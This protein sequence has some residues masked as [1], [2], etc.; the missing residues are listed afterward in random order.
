MGWFIKMNGNKITDL[1]T[2][3]DAHDAVNKSYVD[4]SFAP[5]N[6]ISE[7]S[8]CDTYAECMSKLKSVYSAMANGDK[9]FVRMGI[10]TGGTSNGEL[11]GGGWFFELNRYYAD[12]GHI[13][14]TNELYVFRLSNYGGW[15]KWV[16]ASPSAFAPAGY[17]LGIQIPNLVTDYVND[18]NKLTING[19]YNITAGLQNS[20]VTYGTV[21]VISRDENDVLQIVY[22]RDTGKAPTLQ[23]NKVFGTWGEWKQCD[24]SAFAPA[25]VLLYENASPSSTFAQQLVSVQTNG[26]SHYLIEFNSGTDYAMFRSDCGSASISKVIAN[27]SGTAIAMQER[28]IYIDSRGITF[29]SGSAK[30][31]NSTETYVNDDVFIPYRIYGVKG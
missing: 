29:Y 1:G 27:S 30:Y 2:P 10:G 22:S 13:I 21:D 17:G 4:N 3:T 20:P 9:K 16:D 11:S 26:Y 6:F 5:I 31:V 18:L 8:W 28:K 12:Y 24:P 15:G 14:A 25:K 23:R 19:R 7:Y